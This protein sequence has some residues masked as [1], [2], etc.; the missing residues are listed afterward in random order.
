MSYFS[1]EFGFSTLEVKLRPKFENVIRNELKVT[2]L[3]GAHTLGRANILNS[4]FHG[5]WVQDEAGLF[6]NK[7]FSNLVR[8]SGID[9]RLRQRTCENILDDPSL[10]SEGQTTGWQYTT[11]GTVGF[12]LVADMALYQNFTVDSDGRPDCEYSQCNLSETSR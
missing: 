1:Q 5:T 6:N 4:D 12:N 2:A 3:M 7:Y 10:C 11:S 9:W 8:E